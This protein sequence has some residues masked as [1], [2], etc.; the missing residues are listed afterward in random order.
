LD[1]LE[2]QGSVD[3]PRLV[4]SFSTQAGL[5]VSARGPIGLQVIDCW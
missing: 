5:P 2:S 1:S 3:S 4:R